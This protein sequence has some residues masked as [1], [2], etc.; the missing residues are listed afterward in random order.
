MGDNNASYATTISNTMCPPAV[1]RYTSYSGSARTLTINGLNTSVKYSI[2]LYASRYS[3]GNTSIFN[4]N[5][6][7]VTI[8]TYDNYSNRAA[9]SN[10]TPNAQG[11]L[12]VTID[13]GSTYNYLNG[14]ML[15]EQGATSSIAIHNQPLKEQ[16]ENRT[17]SFEL[18][19]NPSKN[20][21]TISLNNSYSGL[22]KAS[23]TDMNG[24]ILKQIQLIKTEVQKN[25][26]VLVAD[27][28]KGIYMMQLQFGSTKE[29]R[30]LVKW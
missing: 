4:V 22:I 5:G 25:W 20:S 13:K 18:Y 24:R 3:T 30:Q 9:F 8:T 1:L 2:E 23:I 6:S 11:Q 17:A 27:L 12:I 10:I 21:V 14:F 15:M 28:P 19:P 16:P 29:S 26:N 7:S